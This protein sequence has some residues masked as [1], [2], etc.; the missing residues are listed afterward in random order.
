MPS[1]NKML[2]KRF[3]SRLRALRQERGLS[4]AQ[5]GKKVR[6]GSRTILSYEQGKMAPSID[7]IARLARF[8][9]TTTDD[10]IFDDSSRTESMRDRELIDCLLQADQ[11]PRRERTVIKDLVE[12][13][14]SKHQIHESSLAS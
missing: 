1:A 2:L 13:L 9:G 4:Q 6:I 11:L 7:V 12:L 8:F 14:L 3:G 10:L 5:L